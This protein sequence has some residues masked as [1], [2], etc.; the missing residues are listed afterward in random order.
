MKERIAA[1]RKSFLPMMLCVC[2]TAC[3]NATIVNKISLVQTVGYDSDGNGV[4]S[5]ALIAD[6]ETKGA[7]ALRLF[8]THSN[9]VLDTFPRINTKT[10]FPI[11]YGQMRMVIFGDSFAR[12][13]IEPVIS[14]LS[15]SYKSSLRM[16]IGVADRDAADIL[17]VKDNRQRQYFLSDM[18]AQ[19]R[20]NGNIPSTNL[21]ITLFNYY[22]EGRDPYLPYFILE[23]GEVKIDGLALFQHDKF[24][25]SIGIKE[26]FVLKLLLENSKNGS[27][28]VPVRGPNQKRE[29]FIL[30]QSIRSNADYAVIGIGPPASVSI[31]VKM[32]VK[33][34]D[35]PQ[36]LDLA[37]QDQLVWLEKI[38]ATHF[39]QEIRQLVSLCQR[40]RVD[41]L[42]LGDRIRSRSAKWDAQDFLDHYEA[43]NTTV[44]VKAT[45]IQTG[46]R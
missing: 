42:G 34:R 17:N 1:L 38:I 7:A 20:K 24:K 27:Y 37:S 39:E 32:D 46:G 21:Y 22:N 36:W 3:G 31:R 9:T 23:R 33:V 29:E 43:L 8:E 41:P 4:R 12:Q 40:Y 45:I 5:A 14:S 19:N 28:T 11:E 44:S 30:I 35:V 13:G 18:I 15:R 16:H 25:T 26:A 6:Y 2:L 10:N